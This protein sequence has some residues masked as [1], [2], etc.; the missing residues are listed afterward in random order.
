MATEIGVGESR[1]LFDEFFEMV[2]RYMFGTQHA[3]DEKLQFRVLG[4]ASAL[5]MSLFFV[6]SQAGFACW[7]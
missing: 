7:A 3:V 6:K 1:K 5:R 2:R 4:S